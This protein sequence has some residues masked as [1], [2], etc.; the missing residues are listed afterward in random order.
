M[1]VSF[2]G[3]GG[4]PFR[5]DVVPNIKNEDNR[6][7]VEVNDA[8][9]RIFDLSDPEQLKEYERVFD[10]V[11]KGIWYVSME[12]VQY[13]P[14]KQTW[15]ILLRYVEQYMEMPGELERRLHNEFN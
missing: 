1:R 14:I 9:I 15:K 3:V 5:G 4:I 12:N 6:Q 11:A 10:M 2:P 7:P 13:D 8:K